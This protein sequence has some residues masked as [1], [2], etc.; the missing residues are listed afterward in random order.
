MILFAA[1]NHFNQ[2]CGRVLHEVLPESYDIRFYEDDWSGLETDWVDDCE[3]LILNMISG[4][5]NV[6]A[7]SEKATAKVKQYL[8]TG[9]PML[10]LHAASAAFWQCDWWRPIVGWRWVRGNDPDGVVSSHHP[11]RPYTLDVAKCRHPL[12]AKLRSIELPSDEIYLNMEQTAPTVTLMNITTDE[13]TFPQAY[14]TENP[15][16]GE[17]AGYIPGHRPEVVGHPDMVANVCALMDHLL[18]S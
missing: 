17:I 4:A 5:C 10:L 11:V 3:L 14:V 15:W 16:G 13:G 18:E 8:E 7:P 6:E 2:H 12:A 9:K 1:D